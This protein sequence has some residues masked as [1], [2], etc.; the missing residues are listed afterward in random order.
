MTVCR[1]GHL[2]QGEAGVWAPCI[3]CP[4]CTRAVTRATPVPGHR[5]S[6]RRVVVLDPMPALAW[7]ALCA[8]GWAGEARPDEG[9][10]VA[11]HTAHKVAVLSGEWAEL[12]EADR[13]ADVRGRAEPHGVLDLVEARI[14]ARNADLITELRRRP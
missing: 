9:G 3:G 6:V 5:R 10:A 12:F 4:L 8:C 7:A 13:A 14:E 2:V 11:E 1:P